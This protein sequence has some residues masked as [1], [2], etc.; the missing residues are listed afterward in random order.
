MTTQKCIDC[1]YWRPMASYSDDGECSRVGVSVYLQSR[2]VVIDGNIIHNPDGSSPK[3]V[4]DA[5]F[6]CIRW[7]A[8]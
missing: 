5:S 4:T 1:R 6:G 8:P 7:E 3:L 2:H